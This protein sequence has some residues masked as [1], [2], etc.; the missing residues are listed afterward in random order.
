MLY[1]LCKPKFYVKYCNENDDN[2][3]LEV[4]SKS[5]K[6]GFIDIG[7]EN[8]VYQYTLGLQGRKGLID[9]R[10]VRLDYSDNMILISL[11]VGTN[12]ISIGCSKEI[13]NEALLY[14]KD[15]I[16]IRNSS[17]YKSKRDLFF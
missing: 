15:K 12:I 7:S 6:R 14:F 8:I 16:K 13:Y 3:R 4:Y 1:F 10:N 9:L 2:L 11:K 5:K 17:D